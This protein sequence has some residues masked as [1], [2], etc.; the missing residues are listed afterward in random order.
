[1]LSFFFL[2]DIFS[3]FLASPAHLAEPWKVVASG[4]WKVFC[5]RF[6][7]SLKCSCCWKIFKKRQK[8][9]FFGKA[10][11]LS[12]IWLLCFT[13]PGHPKKWLP[14]QGKIL[15][16]GI[17]NPGPKD[18]KKPPNVILRCKVPAHSKIHNAK[19]KT[20]KKWFSWNPLKDFCKR[21]QTGVLV[22]LFAVCNT[23]GGF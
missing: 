15:W 8:H 1:M 11:H 16:C 18:R 13:T 2:K 3:G 9:E 10:A 22:P 14:P 12:P 21:G 6:L 17:R 5:R 20:Q 7:L 23:D 4:P 19:R